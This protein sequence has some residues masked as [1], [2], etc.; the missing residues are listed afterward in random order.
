MKKALL[1]QGPVGPFFEYLKRA[2]I[3][4]NVQVKHVIFNQA[5][6]LFASKQNSIRFSGTIKEWEDWLIKEFEENIPNI[7]ALFGSNRPAHL[8]AI[9]LAKKYQIKLMSLEEGYLRPNYIS[10]E[11]G[12]NNDQS[13]LCDWK[14]SKR[15]KVVK[16]LRLHIAKS[17]K[18]KA[19]WAFLYYL[20]REVQQKDSDVALYHLH[21]KGLINEIKLWSKHLF[22]K[23]LA[24]TTEKKLRNKLTK[25]KCYLIYFNSFASAYRFTNSNCCIGLE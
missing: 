18:S 25:K 21:S 5:D 15:K 22:K 4:Q 12:G 17:F 20:T 23:A 13:P 11:Y 8:V 19:L 2:F 7:I 24:K 14:L 3:K 9:K 16:P 6:A 1:L 10:C